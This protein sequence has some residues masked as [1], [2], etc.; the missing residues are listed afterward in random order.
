MPSSP[1]LRFCSGAGLLPN[2]RRS[3]HFVFEPQARYALPVQ[4]SGAATDGQSK[5]F[6]YALSGP[7]AR[8]VSSSQFNHS[9]HSLFR[10][11][12]NLHP[13]QLNHSAHSGLELLANVCRRVVDAREQLASICEAEAVAQQSAITKNP[14]SVNTAPY[15]LGQWPGGFSAAAQAQFSCQDIA[16][17]AVAHH[18]DAMDRQ[19]LINHFAA[20]IAVPGLWNFPGADMVPRLIAECFDLCFEIDCGHHAR[21]RFGT[22][23]HVLEGVLLQRHDHYKVAYRG[24]IFD[25]PKD[26]DCL[27]H[28][29][30]LLHSFQF[31][32][33]YQTFNFYQAILSGR[34]PGAVNAQH[35]QLP[36][37]NQENVASGREISTTARQAM[38]AQLADFVLNRMSVETRNA[39][40]EAIRGD[41]HQIHMQN[42]TR[43]TTKKKMALPYDN[44][45]SDS[46]LLTISAKNLSL[47]KEWCAIPA[48]ER[49]RIKF[50]N[51]AQQHGV[52]V[53]RV[54]KYIYR[55][56][57]LTI[58]GKQR[59]AY[60]NGTRSFQK[61][62]ERDILDWLE[63][64]KDSDENIA[65]YAD[66]HNLY[67]HSFAFAV[68]SYVKKHSLSSHR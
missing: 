17:W 40:L 50:F 39:L 57:E 31:P 32:E 62:T 64:K 27:L 65:S 47:L 6:S 56:G 44:H 67:A 43:P 11:P 46:K 4:D 29:M 63:K 26:G 41:I 61:C 13:H 7:P 49:K 23:G 5:N 52:S 3:W 37:V 36:L 58:A 2:Q 33:H 30:L 35:L 15:Y 60:E 19:N 21:Q 38:R 42:Q 45:H 28:A 68:R 24:E 66:R 16:A 18:I 59:L 22:R 51:F 12:E 1:N 34:A 54:S 55:N 25:V 8:P 48:E 9:P 53:T 20:Q 10:P 14:V